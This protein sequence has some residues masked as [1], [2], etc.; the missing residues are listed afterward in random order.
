[1]FITTVTRPL[2]AG[3]ITMSLSFFSHFSACCSSLV[4]LLSCSEADCIVEAI[5]L[6][7]LS[8]VGSDRS[9]CRNRTASTLASVGIRLGVTE[10]FSPYDSTRVSVLSKGREEIFLTQLSSGSVRR[11]LSLLRK[12]RVSFCWCPV[13]TRS[14]VLSARLSAIVVTVLSKSV[15]ISCCQVVVVVCC[16][17]S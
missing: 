11:F 5:L 4:K 16:C 17:S 6:L 10:C 15:G 12:S 9:R 1:M 8:L 7:M 2:S 13:R 3:S 14:V